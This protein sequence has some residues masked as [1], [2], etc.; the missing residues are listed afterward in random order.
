ME[1]T[2]KCF[3]CD[4]VK[5]LSAYYKHK[6][7]ADGHL[8]KCKECTKKDVD[9]REK[10]LRNDPEWVEKEKIRARDKYYRLYSDGRHYLSAENKKI[11][12]DKYRAKYP[13]KYLANNKS[14]RLKKEGFEKHHWNYSE[15]FEKDVIWLTKKDHAFIHRYIQYDQERMMYRCTRSEGRYQQGDLLDTK[16]KHIR[17]YLMLKNQNL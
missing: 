16:F 3:K 7:M 4:Q 5:P 9:H 10:R 6:Q 1:Q 11:A 14:Q 15:G 13:E 17:Y 2:K 8:N 12:M